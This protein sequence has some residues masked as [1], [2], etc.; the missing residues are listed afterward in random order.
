MDTS[1]HVLTR[2]RGFGEEKGRQLSVQLRNK[3]WEG[4]KITQSF[5]SDPLYAKSPLCKVRIRVRAFCDAPCFSS[6]PLFLYFTVVRTPHGLCYGSA[7]PRIGSSAEVLGLPSAMRP[8]PII[9]GKEERREKLGGER[10]RVVLVVEVVGLGEGRCGCL[11][12]R[13]PFC[14]CAPLIS[15]K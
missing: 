5:D 7:Y 12:N 14:N 9:N 8:L 11:G 6:S 13:S 10:G 4:K 2:R 1:A 15:W 3:Q